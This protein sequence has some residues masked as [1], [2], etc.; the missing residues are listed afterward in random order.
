[1]FNT[2]PLTRSRQLIAAGLGW[3]T[4]PIGSL[5][6]ANMH[7]LF[8]I[9]DLAVTNMPET[10]KAKLQIVAGDIMDRLAPAPGSADLQQPPFNTRGA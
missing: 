7:Q 10:D 6:T 2:N 9:I 1:M 4:A 8:Q 5:L 3:P